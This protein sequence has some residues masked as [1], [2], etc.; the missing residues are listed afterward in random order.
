MV[1]ILV[2]VVA[3]HHSGVAGGMFAG[4][5]VEC[6]DCQAGSVR[7]NQFS[8]CKPAVMLGLDAG[9]LLEGIAVFY[10]QRH[11]IKARQR[12]RGDS[13]RS[14]GASKVSEFTVVGG[15]SIKSTRRNH[16]SLMRSNDLS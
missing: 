4:S 5:A 16:A 6:V 2:R 11:T 15:S 14:T 12:L 1:R 7:E 3:I 9:I 10:G 13:Q 8:G